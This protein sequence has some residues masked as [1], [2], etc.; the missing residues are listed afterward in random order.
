MKEYSVFQ[1]HYRS[2][3]NEYMPE[4][5]YWTNTF[6]SHYRSDFNWTEQFIFIILINFNPIIG[7][8]LTS[9][10][11]TPVEDYIIISIPL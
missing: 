11:D 10:E 8:I 6:Q 5:Y 1:S 2:D 7:L 4:F 9:V 3:F